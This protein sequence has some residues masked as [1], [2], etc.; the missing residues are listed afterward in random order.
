M[1]REIT[2]LTYHELYQKAA[3]RSGKQEVERIVNYAFANRGELGDRDFSTKIVS[4]L[5]TLCKEDGPLIVL[6]YSPPFYP[7]VSSTEDPHIQATLKRIQIEAKKSY[8]LEIEE[9]KYF[10]G[11]SDLSYLQLEKQDS[12]SLHDQYAAL[13]KRLFFTRRRKGS[14]LRSSHQ[15]GSVRKGPT[16]MDRAP[17]HPVLIW[18]FARII[19]V[20]DSCFVREK[21]SI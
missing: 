1:I 7:A 20:S 6:F 4:E 16:Q 18:H 19:R 8:G 21:V 10:P 9:V 15:R 17:A 14:T 3:E 5:T 11:L 2:V 12:R 13:P